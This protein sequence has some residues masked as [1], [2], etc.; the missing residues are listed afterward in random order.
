MTPTTTKAAG[1]E[2]ALASANKWSRRRAREVNGP[3][4]RP[5]SPGPARGEN[6]G[7][8]SSPRASTSKD[9]GSPYFK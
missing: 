2:Q 9:Y 1:A 5:C 7:G 3:R 4:G 6:N 8:A